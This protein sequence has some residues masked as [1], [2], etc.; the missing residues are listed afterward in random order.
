[1]GA[2]SSKLPDLAPASQFVQ[3]TTNRTEPSRA[4]PAHPIDSRLCPGICPGRKRDATTTT[5]MKLNGFAAIACLRAAKMTAMWLLLILL[6]LLLSCRRQVVPTTQQRR[7]AHFS[8][9][10][11]QTD[12]ENAE[13]SKI[14]QLLLYG[15]EPMRMLPKRMI[16]CFGARE[17]E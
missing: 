8:V 13:A 15:F 1:M 7:Y 5:C 10:Q 16:G 4:E 9:E 3:A 2:K 14:F 11:Q 12:D 6:L 17:R